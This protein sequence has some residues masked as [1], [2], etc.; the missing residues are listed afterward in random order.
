MK[1]ELCGYNGAQQGRFSA[2]GDKGCD[3]GGQPQCPDQ[4]GGCQHPDSRHQAVS[5]S[6]ELR[7]SRSCSTARHSSVEALRRTVSGFRA[8]RGVDKD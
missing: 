7:M 1:I 2:T 3:P 4:F 5:K 6:A 8:S